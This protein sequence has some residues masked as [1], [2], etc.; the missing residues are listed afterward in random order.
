MV[1]MDYAILTA[2]L[3][4]TLVLPESLNANLT[5]NSV[6]GVVQLYLDDPD[7]AQYIWMNSAQFAANRAILDPLDPWL[8]E[9]LDSQYVALTHAGEALDILFGTE[10]PIDHCI[11][12]P[13]EEQC[14]VVVNRMLIA[15]IVACNIGKLVCLISLLRLER[16][17]PL[18]T[19]GDAVADF[20]RDED[21]TT[22]GQGPIS[23]RDIRQGEP[24]CLQSSPP[25]S[26]S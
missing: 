8:V 2:Q 25:Q 17:S 22:R 26:P 10:T 15:I 24:T 9:T 7:N 1:V 21:V 13:G 6:A 12:L 19:V 16:F 3:G 20:L 18:T 11:A 5:S 23:F 14:T 4:L